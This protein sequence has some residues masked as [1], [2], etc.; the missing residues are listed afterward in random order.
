MTIIILR[1]MAMKK[2]RIQNE[3]YE[4]DWGNN[5][6]SLYQAAIFKPTR[7]AGRFS[8]RGKTGS[9]FR[10]KSCAIVRTRNKGCALL[11]VFL[12]L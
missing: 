6:F 10:N 11:I 9:D 1:A 8:R 4:V 7:K 3:D 12:E 2:M 5:L